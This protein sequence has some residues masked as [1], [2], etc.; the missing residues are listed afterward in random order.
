[1]SINGTGMFDG[2]RDVCISVLGAVADWITLAVDKIRFEA[3]RVGWFASISVV[4]TC[5]SCRVVV[6]VWC[7][8]VWI[9]EFKRK[10]KKE[11][12]TES[13]WEEEEGKGERRVRE[14]RRERG[15]REREEREKS[16][17][18]RS[19]NSNKNNNQ[20]STTNKLTTTLNITLRC[21][22][23]CVICTYRY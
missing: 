5:V 21:Q 13:E 16:E 2:C 22:N 15:E 9:L 4:G 7:G 6:C 14:E 10:K 23:T 1:M 20:I 3:G 12:K 18:R 19:N 17:R 8:V 11:K